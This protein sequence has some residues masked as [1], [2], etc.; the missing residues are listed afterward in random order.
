VSSFLVAASLG[1][2]DDI[3]SVLPQES[4]SVDPLFLG[5]SEELD[6]IRGEWRLAPVIRVPST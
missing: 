1:L 6:D 2:G 4:L 3:L 5:G